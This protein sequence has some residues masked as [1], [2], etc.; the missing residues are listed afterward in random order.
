MFDKLESALEITHGHTAL[1]IDVDVV[2][3]HSDFRVIRRDLLVDFVQPVSWSRQA[4]FMRILRYSHRLNL[5]DELGG[6]FLE[7][8]WLKGLSVATTET[9]IFIL[10][11]VFSNQFSQFVSLLDDA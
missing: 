11:L 9:Y 4:T 3:R 2:Q 1:S 6:C 5:L 10:A 7:R 8:A